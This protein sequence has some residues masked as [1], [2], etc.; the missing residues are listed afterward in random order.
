MIRTKGVPIKVKEEPLTD[1]SIMTFGM[2][3]GKALANVEDSW[4][5]WFYEKNFL[6]KKHYGINK[7][8]M[9]YINDNKE[10]IFK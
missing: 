5:R 6:K 1:Q 7:L 10:S 4:L 8:L 9:N 2:F 3:K